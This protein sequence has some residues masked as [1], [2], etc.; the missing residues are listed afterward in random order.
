MGTVL[1][2][3]FCLRRPAV[4]HSLPVSF[5]MGTF[6]VRGVAPYLW[7]IFIY[8]YYLTGKYHHLMEYISTMTKLED[9]MVKA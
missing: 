8:F 1:M 7:P 4:R 5:T 9:L 2:P 6:P 3:G